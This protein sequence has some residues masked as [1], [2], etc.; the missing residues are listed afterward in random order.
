MSA[1]PESP[2]EQ[3]T[4]D[5]VMKDLLRVA[6]ASGSLLKTFFQK[7]DLVISEKTGPQYLV[8]EADAAAEKLIM[9]F[10]AEHYPND[11][12]HSEESG[13][14]DLIATAE[15]VWVIDP[16]DGTYNFAHGV[17]RFGTMICRGRNAFAT[18]EYAV[19][20]IS[21]I[22]YA[23]VYSPTLELTGWAIK[24]HGTWLNGERVIADD[25]Q[26][27]Q[28]AIIAWDKLGAYLPTEKNDP[29]EAALDKLQ[30]V[31]KRL[32]KEPAKVRSAAI[33][34]LWLLAGRLTVESMNHRFA[35]DFAPVQLLAAEAGFT[36]ARFSGEPIQWHQ[37]EGGHLIAPPTLHAEIRELIQHPV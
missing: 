32:Q 20:D 17:E 33:E 8:T 6:Q 35:W 26:T 13:E 18:G 34:V 24:G 4:D 23:V 3:Y 27:L 11:A 10:I 30:V 12:I 37:P 36:V 28:D 22:E 29:G 9:E 5:L 14:N 2:F 1:L 31:L 7:K 16:L 25:S 19:K 15:N 21:T